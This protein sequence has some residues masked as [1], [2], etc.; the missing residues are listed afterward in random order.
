VVNYV[1]HELDCH[2]CGCGV[3]CRFD[4]RGNGTWTALLIWAVLLILDSGLPK[5]TASW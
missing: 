4:C 5:N 3:D 1:V 2:G